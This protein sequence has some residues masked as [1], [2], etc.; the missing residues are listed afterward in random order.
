MLEY[1]AITLGEADMHL[2]IQAE[3]I[4]RNVNTA[5]STRIAV[6][7]SEDIISTFGCSRWKKV[8]CA[9]AVAACTAACVVTGSA[10]CINCFAAVGSGCIDCL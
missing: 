1:L 5:K 3:P 8:A 9:G 10:A 4:I 2:P 7:P 6:M